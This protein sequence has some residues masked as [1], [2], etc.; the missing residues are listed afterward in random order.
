MITFRQGCVV[1]HS[2]YTEEELV[3]EL[4]NVHAEIPR[5]VVKLLSEI[6]NLLAF[7]ATIEAAHDAATPIL[8]LPLWS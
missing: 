5:C 8:V 4:H 3:G 1:P 7:N 2:G 6:A